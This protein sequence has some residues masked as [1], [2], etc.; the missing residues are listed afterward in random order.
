[1]RTIIERSRRGLI[2]HKTINREFPE[3]KKGGQDHE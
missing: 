1:M 3:F 2:Y